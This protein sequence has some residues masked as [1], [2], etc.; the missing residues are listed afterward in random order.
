MTTLLSDKLPRGLQAG[1]LDLFHIPANATLILPSTENC[2]KYLESKNYQYIGNLFDDIF[3]RKDLIGSKFNI[4]LQE[5]ERAF[6]LF[7]SKLDQDREDVLDKFFAV[8]GDGGFSKWE[9]YYFNFE[10]K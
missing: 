2:G 8:S 7:S 9:D 10:L 3:V 5:V 4:D 6:P 1:A